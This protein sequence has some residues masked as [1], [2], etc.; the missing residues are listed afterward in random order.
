MGASGV[1]P[2]QDL[3]GVRG[4]HPRRPRRV[5]RQGQGGGAQGARVRQR[6]AA[7]AEG[8]RGA[9]RVPRSHRLRRLLQARALH[10]SRHGG[11][12]HQEDRARGDAHGAQGA[13]RGPPRD[14]WQRGWHLH[15]RR[16]QPRHPRG[17]A[18]GSHHDG[19]R[20]GPS[21]GF[22]L[23]RAGEHPAG[24]RH[25]PRRGRD[26]RRGPLHRQGARRGHERL[27]PH[28]RAHERQLRHLRHRGAVLRG[29]HLRHHRRPVRDADDH[30]RRRRHRP[31]PVPRRRALPAVPR[32]HH[33]HP[34]SQ[35][36]HRVQAPRG[37]RS[38][39]VHDP[40]QQ[41]RRPLTPGEAHENP[42]PVPGGQLPPPAQGDRAQARV[43]GGH[44]RRQSRHRPHLPP[45]HQGG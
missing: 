10:G 27:P 18:Q 41:P 30:H 26:H 12:D 19:A 23:Q 3:R 24:V 17:D 21:G 45:R 5:H 13:H 31:E 4:R 22:L 38:R 37:V 9:A 16:R 2:D 11:G 34:G 40:R 39:Q 29:Q 44:R 8:P 15:R 14:G 25:P 36:L 6:V 28:C 35:D 1:R 32:V 33:G 43:P 42:R 7:A 20:G